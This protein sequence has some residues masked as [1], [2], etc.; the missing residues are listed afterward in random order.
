M[1]KDDGKDEDDVEINTYEDM[2]DDSPSTVFNKIAISEDKDLLDPNVNMDSISNIFHSILGT[3][4]NSFLNEFDVDANN[5]DNIVKLN[6]RDTDI[7]NT[8]SMTQ[9]RSNTI[10]GIQSTTE[11]TDY[12]RMYMFNYIAGYTSS[13]SVGAGAGLKSSEYKGGKAIKPNK[14][15]IEE[16]EEEKDNAL[17]SIENK[18][19]TDIATLKQG[20]QEGDSELKQGIQEGDSELKQGIQEGD[21]ELKQGIQEGDSELKQGIQEGEAAVE[22]SVS[23]EEAA[24]QAIVSKEEAVAEA[25]AQAE[26]TK[27][28][29][30]APAVEAPTV[31]APPTAT[32]EAAVEAEA[33]AE[34]AVE[35][36]LSDRY[37]EYSY[38]NN[39]LTH[40]IKE[41]DEYDKLDDDALIDVWPID[42]DISR[43]YLKE[44]KNI[45]VFYQY[46][47]NYYIN[48]INNIL[49]SYLIND[50]YFIRDAIFFFFINHFNSNE[51][52]FLEITDEEKK[53]GILNE[54]FNLRIPEWS[55]DNKYLTSIKK[56]KKEEIIEKT[57]ASGQ[58]GGNDDDEAILSLQIINMTTSLGPVTPVFN[59]V[60]KT[61]TIGRTIITTQDQLIDVLQG[62][63]TGLIDGLM[64]Q[65]LTEGTD[66]YQ[67]PTNFNTI[68]DDL[69]TQLKQEYVSNPKNKS[70]IQQLKP[71][72]KGVG[73][74]F[75]LINK[76]ITGTGRLRGARP[77]NLENSINNAINTITTNLKARIIKL[78]SVVMYNK[79]KIQGT[80]T[81]SLSREAQVPVNIFIKNV[82]KDN[83]I[84][85]YSL[86][87]RIGYVFL[88]LCQ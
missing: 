18:K 66:N 40:I 22:A 41:F 17:M 87:L 7:R 74:L 62:V 88:K 47:F 70:Y 9:L 6:A 12:I 23:K 48:N 78:V 67:V 11:M 35:T 25:A 8:R 14:S 31:E 29:E 46:I 52:K 32:V 34:E 21:S 60:S 42:T 43:P 26:A 75:T 13:A 49:S 81:T 54:I 58:K 76:Y 71:K 3:D 39:A 82:N 38:L 55:D 37:Q 79:I 44:T 53:K 28:V 86:I 64:S 83:T 56:N 15:M 72:K 33:E 19:K 36:T 68:I 85:V 5:M 20:I 73:S 65:I 63:Y 2:K 24:T 69:Q 30:A 4:Y 61:V 50:S 77:E 45:F 80:K 51:E 16:I 57:I 1:V 59:D 27:A 84:V 10:N